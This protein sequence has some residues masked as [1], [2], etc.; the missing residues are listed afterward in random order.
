MQNTPAL[1]V[2]MIPIV[3]GG[4]LIAG[5]LYGVARAGVAASNLDISVAGASINLRGIGLDTL[6]GAPVPGSIVIRVWNQSNS[7]VSLSQIML[8]V[9]LGQTQIATIENGQLF[10]A[11]RS[12]QNYQLSTRYNV[13][14]IISIAR[15]ALSGGFKDL[16]T[17]R[18]QG[19]V[20]AGAV[21][22]NIDHSTKLSI[23]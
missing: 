8:R 5:I 20:F 22:V 15:A 23:V 19:R 10:I 21:P 12:H 16:G 4:L 7:G 18:I 2:G 11:P 6:L 17:V 13:S 14:S 9:Y 1:F 3:I